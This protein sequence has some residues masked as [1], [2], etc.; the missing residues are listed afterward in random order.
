METLF[1]AESFLQ[2][3]LDE[4]DV[5]V[6]LRPTCASCVGATPLTKLKGEVRWI[7]Q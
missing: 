1:A 2:D 5:K 3:E 6:L 7:I 4:L